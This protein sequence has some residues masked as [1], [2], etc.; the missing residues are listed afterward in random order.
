VN[1]AVP[2]PLAVPVIAPVLELRL[3]HEGK[4]PEATAHEL[5]PQPDCVAVCE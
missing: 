1:V 5:E 2:L 3:A 4:D